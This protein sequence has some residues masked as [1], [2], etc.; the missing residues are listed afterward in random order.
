MTEPRTV[1][2]QMIPDDSGGHREGSHRREAGGES[3][4]E[5]GVTAFGDAGRGQE[6]WHVGSPRGGK[7]P[8]DGFPLSLQEEPALP[9]SARSR[10]ALF[11]PAGLWQTLQRAQ[12][13]NGETP[14]YD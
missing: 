4:A 1:R 13:A 3:E 11:T 14:T 12:A 5:A 7:R 8:G 2:W 10:L 9:K 6:L